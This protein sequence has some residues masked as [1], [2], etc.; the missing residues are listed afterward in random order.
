M[1]GAGDATLYAAF[2]ACISYLGKR[3][4]DT[5]AAS[6][7]DAIHERDT[8]K[9]ERNELQRLIDEHYESVQA[10]KI[11]AIAEERRLRTE[12]DRLRSE[13]DRLSSSHSGQTGTTETPNRTTDRSSS[14]GN[15]YRIRRP[16][17]ERFEKTE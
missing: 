8:V 6:R 5:L 16:S 11:A 17:R 9:D 3:L 13:V 10:D 2:I 15:G 1:N 12:L 14:Q 7:E 4:F